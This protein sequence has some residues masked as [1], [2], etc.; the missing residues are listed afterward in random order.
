MINCP[1]DSFGFLFI[2]AGNIGHKRYGK[3]ACLF[4]Q[5]GTEMPDL[6]LSTTNGSHGIYRTNFYFHSFW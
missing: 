5:S 6:L 3:E 1:E 2:F 4:M